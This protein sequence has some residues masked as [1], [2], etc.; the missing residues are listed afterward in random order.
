MTPVIAYR[1]LVKEDDREAP[2]FL[3]ESVEN[4]QKTV[5]MVHYTSSSSL[6]LL[7]ED[8]ACGGVWLFF[9]SFSS[10]E[11]TI[12]HPWVLGYIYI[13]IEREREDKG[14]SKQGVQFY[15]AD[16]AWWVHNHPWK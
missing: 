16:T 9:E 10:I 3:F 14:L 13:Y 6:L 2:S 15:R 4:G 12:W 7:Q 11:P 5:N 1:C 8:R